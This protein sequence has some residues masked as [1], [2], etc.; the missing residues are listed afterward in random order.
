MRVSNEQEQVVR[1]G[2]PYYDEV[3]R[4]AEQEERREGE[5]KRR[6]FRGRLGSR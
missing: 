4:G 1:V 5:K 6:P 2:F 3:I